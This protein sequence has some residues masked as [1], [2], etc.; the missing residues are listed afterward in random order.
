MQITLREIRH[1]FYLLNDLTVL[2][3]VLE[4]VYQLSGVDQLISH[5]GEQ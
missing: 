1:S 3:I 5:L 4:M 2:K